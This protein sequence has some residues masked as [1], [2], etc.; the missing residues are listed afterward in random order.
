MTM[1]DFQS[2]RHVPAAAAARRAL[3]V[4]RPYLP[5]LENWNHRAARIS[6]ILLSHITIEAEKA[7]QRELLAGLIEEVAAARAEF[8][9]AV[10]HEPRHSRISDV[11]AALN[12]LLSILQGVR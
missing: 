6:G 11:Q 8:E 1:N 5:R 7:R 2:A 9:E 10:E 12:R 3:E 4:V